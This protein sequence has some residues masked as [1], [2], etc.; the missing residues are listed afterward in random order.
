MKFYVIDINLVTFLLYYT[1]YLMDHRWDTVCGKWKEVHFRS[2]LTYPPF[3]SETAII[4][5]DNTNILWYIRY[6]RCNTDCTTT[7]QTYLLVLHVPV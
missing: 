3:H 2:Y 7:T 4:H 6:Y 1:L 5:I